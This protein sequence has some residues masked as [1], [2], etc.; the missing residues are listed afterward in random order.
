M[1]AASKKK[2]PGSV[3]GVRR[4]RPPDVYLIR[5]LFATAGATL[6]RWSRSSPS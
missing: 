6:G 5:I 1:R 2:T 3:P 4:S